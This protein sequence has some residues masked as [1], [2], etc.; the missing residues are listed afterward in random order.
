MLSDEVTMK[1][2]DQ[3]REL[4]VLFE[5]QVLTAVVVFK[6]RLYLWLRSLAKQVALVE[7]VDTAE[8]RT[9]ME[10]DDRVHLLRTT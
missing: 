8:K 5:V 9:T 2:I 10:T 6:V 1:P 7:K 3:N 4:S